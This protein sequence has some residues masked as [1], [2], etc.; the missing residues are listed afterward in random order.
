MTSPAYLRD[1]SL[2]FRSKGTATHIA[3][4]DRLLEIAGEL[5]TL[6]SGRPV[7]APPR[8]LTRGID[9]KLAEMR[10]VPVP[11]PAE[12]AEIRGLIGGKP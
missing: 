5:D 9:A 11:T 4:A 3:T 12:M 6:T 8:D 1:L 10:R 2:K 7:A